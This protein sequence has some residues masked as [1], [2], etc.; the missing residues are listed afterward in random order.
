[1]AKIQLKS[2][3]IN[4]FGGLFSIFNQFDRSGLRQVIDGHLGRRGAHCE[5]FYVRASN[6]HS[7]RTE[8]MEHAGWTETGVGDHRCGVTS[9]KFD[10]MLPEMNLRLV[11]QRTPVTDEDPAAEPEGIFG[12]EYVYRCIVTDDWDSPERDVIIYY[13]QRGASERN[14]DCKNN[15]FGWAHLPFSFLNENTVFLIATA[16]LK[17][18]YLHLLDVIGGRVKGLDRTA[19]LKRFL[20]TFV[21]VPAKWIKSGR[22]NVLNLY[23]KRR[24]YLELLR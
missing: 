18:F 23:T 10:T 6:C 24:I 2:D 14:F 21:I 19:R 20:R 9:F 12:T 8:F 16:I 3:N 1:M 22:R 5:R 7:R 13:N 11:V 15:D 17:N 4:P